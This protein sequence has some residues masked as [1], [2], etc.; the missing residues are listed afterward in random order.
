M[1]P[2]Q[3]LILLAICVLLGAVFLSS[4]NQEE[5]ES[6]SESVTV[7]EAPSSVSSPT[8]SRSR[9]ALRAPS[10]QLVDQ[11]HEQPVENE[12][13]APSPQAPSQKISP[14][15]KFQKRI[16]RQIGRKSSPSSRAS[17]SFASLLR[18][19]GGHSTRGLVAGIESFRSEGALS[20]EERAAA[21]E[22]LGNPNAPEFLSESEWR[23][24]VDELIT[25]LRV[26]GADNSEL[27][28]QLAT[29][30]TDTNF[31]LVVRDYA[32]QHLGHIR[33]EWGDPDVIDA[34]L[35][36]ALA[37]TENTLAGT[38]F[39][40]KAVKSDFEVYFKLLMVWLILR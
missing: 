21:L 8:D 15:T 10:D 27:S 2:H 11:A 39:H 33:E 3:F 7:E 19:G 18:L 38:A 1:K 13:A 5:V 22:F 4:R 28:N 36:S 30:A 14:R 20:S 35:R 34:T 40:E 17:F 29:I 37:E 12:A 6:R 31:D 25:T 16:E 9:I 24:L 23:W 32:L 26:D